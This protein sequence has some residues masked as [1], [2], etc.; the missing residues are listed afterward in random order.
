MNEKLSAG[1]MEKKMTQKIQLC[2]HYVCYL[3]KRGTK[4]NPLLQNAWDK[5][6]NAKRLLKNFAGKESLIS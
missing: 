3:Q 6:E 1:A 5:K 4:T 2:L